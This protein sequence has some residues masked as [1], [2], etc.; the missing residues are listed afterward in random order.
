[1]CVYIVMLLM[2]VLSIWDLDLEL[3]IH[4]SLFSISYVNLKVTTQ[5]AVYQ[6][7]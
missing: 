6:R 7:L 1:M 2:D 4:L 5:L 3:F